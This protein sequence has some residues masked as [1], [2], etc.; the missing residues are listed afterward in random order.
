MLVSLLMMAL[1]AETPAGLDLEGWMRLAHEN[2]PVV[3]QLSASRMQAEASFITTRAALLP[4]LNFSA[5]GGY[6]WADREAASYSAGFSLSQEL[7]VLA[8]LAGVRTTQAASLGRRETELEREAAILALEQTVAR[9]FYRVVEAG[10]LARSAD[11]AHSRS[12]AVLSRAGMLFELGAANALDLSSA[13]VQETGDRLAVMERLS[14]FENALADLRV[15]AGVAG[16]RSLSVD[17]SGVPEPLDEA[18]FSS[19]PEYTGNSPSLDASRIGL[20]RA[21]LEAAAASASFLPS[22]SVGGSVGWN[23]DEPD[24]GDLD[25]NT[26]WS[27]KLS[28]DW[29]LYDGWLRNGQLMSARASLLRAGAELS[30]AGD[31]NAA[32]AVQLREALLSSIRGLE[33][34]K[35]RV[36][37]AAEKAEL[38]LLRHRMGA[39][40][41]AGLLEAQAELAEAEAARVTAVADCLIAE[42]D[43]LVLCG[44]SPRVGE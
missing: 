31:E 40:E 33:L 39:L 5:A 10:G 26:S 21:E 34:S 13:R 17:T 38:A 27:V 8:G 18:A 11:A 22:L 36:E 32:A 15:A 43:Y 30:E 41:L 25:E 44:I 42:V 7:P 29:P 23:N 37:Y 3:E 4:K 9:A 19:L 1:V 2:S 35:L 16:D 28:L 6:S 24:F 12:T 20:E 14:D